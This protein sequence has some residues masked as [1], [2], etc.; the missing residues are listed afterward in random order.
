MIGT[1][2][3]VILRLLKIILAQAG[4]NCN[5]FLRDLTP[6]LFFAHGQGAGERV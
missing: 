2:L 5:C 4:E 3:V 6:A 1:F